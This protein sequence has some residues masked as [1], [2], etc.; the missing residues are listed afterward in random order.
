MRAL[1]IEEIEAAA[2]AID[3]FARRTPVLEAGEI[4]RRVG[5]PVRLKAECLQATG[6]FK[7][8]GAFNALAG[9]SRD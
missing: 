1:T 5:V 8:R 3:G 2:K 6:S 7:V 9:L 4:S